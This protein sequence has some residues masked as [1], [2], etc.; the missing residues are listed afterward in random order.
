MSVSS[1]RISDLDAQLSSVC[2]ELQAAHVQHKQQLAESAVHRE[3]EKQRAFLDK[4]ASLDRLRSDTERI[5][6]DLE[7]RHLQEKEA[8]QERVSRGKKN[9]TIKFQKGSV[10][11]IIA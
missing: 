4:Q 8:E 10:Y 9:D 11:S 5:R 2:E 3:E 1:Q 6:H 7:R